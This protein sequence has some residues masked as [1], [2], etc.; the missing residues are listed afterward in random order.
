MLIYYYYVLIEVLDKK[1]KKSPLIKKTKFGFVIKIKKNQ[2]LR[3]GGS[4]RRD[5]GL[6]KP[7]KYVYTEAKPSKTSWSLNET[8]F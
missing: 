3:I 4:I 6:F 7:C 8:Y 5:G 1:A 2:F